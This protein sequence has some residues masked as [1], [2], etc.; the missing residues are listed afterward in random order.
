MSCDHITNPSLNTGKKNTSNFRKPTTPYKVIMLPQSKGSNAA[1]KVHAIMA[2]L[3]NEEE[4][5]EAKIAFIEYLDNNPE[6]T[7]EPE[8]FQWEAMMSR[9]SKWLSIKALTIQSVPSNDSKLMNVNTQI[10]NGKKIVET[11]VLIDC[12]AQGAFMDE[13]FMKKHQ[14]PLIKLKK[15]IPVSNVDKT[16]N[17]NGPIKSYTWLSV[18]FDGNIISTWFYISHLGKENIIFR[19]PWLEMVKPIVDW[20][21]KTLK[22]I[23]KQIR[24]PTKSQN[25]DWI[26]QTLRMDLEWEKIESKEAFAEWLWNLLIRKV[27]RK[28]STISIEEIPDKDTTPKF[29]RLSGNKE[30]ILIAVNELPDQYEDMPAWEPDNEGNEE[31]LVEGDLLIVHLKGETVEPK[32]EEKKELLNQPIQVDNT[33]ISIQAK[34]SISQSLAHEAEMNERKSFED[35]VPK[36]YHEYRSVFKKTA[37]E[38]F[39]ERWSWDHR[40]D[41][42]SE[43]IPKKS[44]IY[45]L[46]Q[47]EEEDMNKFIN[48]NLKKGFICKSTSPQVSPFF[49]V[50]KKDSQVLRPCQDYRYLNE[51]TIKNVYPLPSIDNLLLKLHGAE[52]FM[53]LHIQWGYNNVWIKEG[54]EWKGAFIT[55][56]G[57]FEL[58]VMFFG[59][60]NLPT[61]FQSMMNDYF[62]DMIAQGW[63]LIYINNILIFSKNPK[64]HHVRTIQAL[65]QLREK[66]LFLKPEKCIFNAKEVKY[67]GFIVKPN[68]ISMDPTKR[69]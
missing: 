55:K 34:M 10:I 39:P 65:K 52:I 20:A 54:D 16:P 4:L 57:L 40:I 69:S 64:E 51:S 26:I 67:L 62:A 30:Y 42:K 13:W 24:K 15:E 5:K 59:M 43:F 25:K 8:D 18:K 1:Q 38:R 47:K 3:D 2:E 37:S 45:P 28:K 44:K 41:L 7:E 61:T 63:V 50:S 60:T 29:E 58:T 27:Q 21:K 19:L 11:K 56:R 23:P 53:K 6:S 66:D 12:G 32:L 48:D 31:G 49:F 46:N 68:E 14:L 17:R 9:P 35:L 33:K 36:E 22:I